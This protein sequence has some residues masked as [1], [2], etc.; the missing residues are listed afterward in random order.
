MMGGGGRAAKE[1]EKMLHGCLTTYS[2][3]GQNMLRQ[4]CRQLISESLWPWGLGASG[5]TWGPGPSGPGVSRRQ[6]LPRIV[7]ISANVTRPTAAPKSVRGL[8]APLGPFSPFP[9]YLVPGDHVLH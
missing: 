5:G 7:P 3:E 6:V 9:L 8:K 2:P 1:K 4:V